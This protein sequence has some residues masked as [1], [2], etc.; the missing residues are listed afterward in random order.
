MKFLV[1]AA[2]VLMSSAAFAAEK[3]VLDC[4]I[5]SQSNVVTLKLNV[6]E[7]TAAD[8]VTVSLSERSGGTV[9]FSQL[10]KGELAK[11][12]AANFVNLLVLTDQTAQPDGVITNSGFLAA[13]RQQ[14][15]SFGGFLAAK[16]N[17]Y[18]I[19]CQLVP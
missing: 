11:Q 17:I 12:L 14:D 1:S 5:P 8:F 3:T 6:S 15:G 16:G 2:L 9:F 18:P 13:G 10:E 19:A 7:E 4:V